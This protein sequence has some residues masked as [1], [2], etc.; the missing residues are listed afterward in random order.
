[1]L[2]FYALKYPFHFLWK[3]IQ[4]KGFTLLVKD[5][6]T[7]TYKWIH[8]HKIYSCIKMSCINSASDNFKI[9]KL[10]SLSVKKNLRVQTERF[11]KTT[12]IHRRFDFYCCWFC[13]IDKKQIIPC[14]ATK[15]KL[16]LK[17]V[18]SLTRYS[19]WVLQVDTVTAG[20][21]KHV[22]YIVCTFFLTN[23]YTWACPSFNLRFA[24]RVKDCQVVSLLFSA[25]PITT[26]AVC[27]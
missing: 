19:H 13:F 24:P 15:E 11:W 7:L 12:W 4:R 6:C 17:E 9:F 8:I 18:Y 27:I 10:W 5:T 21:R 1:M 25:K 23:F 16:V 3:I 14:Q 20:F 26:F 2:K 22:E